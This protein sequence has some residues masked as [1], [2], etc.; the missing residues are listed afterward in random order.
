MSLT[1]L[2]PLALLSMPF[3]L[4]LAGLVGQLRRRRGSQRELVVLVELLAQLTHERRT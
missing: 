1:T 3:A 4:A 2:T